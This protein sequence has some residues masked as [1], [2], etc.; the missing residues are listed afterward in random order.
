MET[1]HT[2]NSL[3]ASGAKA[4]A[5]YLIE[6]ISSGEMRPGYKLP[7]ERAL[8]QQF[9]ASRGTVRRVLS[10]LK[11]QGFITQTVGSGTFVADKVSAEP[12]LE[13]ALHV[14][15]AE[16]ME[17]RLLIEPLLPKLIVQHATRADFLKMRECIDKS[18][19]AKTIEEFEYWDGALHQV[20]AEATH[21]NFI[22]QLLALVTKVR[23]QGEWGRLKHDSMT[24]QRRQVYQE[25]H[26]DI[27]TALQNR[28]EA[29][30]R[31]LIEGHLVQIRE[32][33]FSR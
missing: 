7:A 19:A 23:E 6:A 22:L 18:E 8:S 27:V 12:A 30:A 17:G 2:P 1:P 10:D 4:L 15:P 11:E 16:L 9:Q 33:L 28:D 5:K 29:Q 31:R 24:P 13:E 32:N 21:N 3:R 26:R 20:F 25:Q 14:S